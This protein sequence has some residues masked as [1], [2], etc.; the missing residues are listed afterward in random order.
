MTDHAPI[1]L[2]I[3]FGEAREKSKGQRMNT[4]ILQSE[5]SCIDLRTHINTFFE[6]N[7]GTTSQANLW[8]AFK[9]YIRGILIQQT[10]L[11][12]KQD[13]LKISNYEDLKG[14]EKEY[15]ENTNEACQ[16]SLVKAKYRLNTVF[17]K[18]AE[19]SLYRLK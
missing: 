10:A 12:K 14:L 2:V 19:Y 5:M 9:A 11:I 16:A 3:V 1:D 7:N 18:K 4:S 6:T 15:W 17:T 8:D 13:N